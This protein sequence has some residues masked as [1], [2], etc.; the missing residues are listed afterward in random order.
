MET[1]PFIKKADIGYHKHGNDIATLRKLLQGDWE[2]IVAHSYRKANQC[3]DYL[4]KVGARGDYPFR[5][6]VF[7][8][9]RSDYL[10]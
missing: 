5:V 10:F 2:V 3:A 6:E 9:G 7:I 8:G 1:L 4:A